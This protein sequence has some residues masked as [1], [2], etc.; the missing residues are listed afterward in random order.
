MSKKA[1]DIKP[2][3][4]NVKKWVLLKKLVAERFGPKKHVTVEHMRGFQ[5]TVAH[6][7]S[8]QVKYWIVQKVLNPKLMQDLGPFSKR[9]HN[10]SGLLDPFSIPLLAGQADG[11][12]PG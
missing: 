10:F 9:L 3:D 5:K 4:A 1:P 2:T 7:A 11:A 6:S 8:I 12:C